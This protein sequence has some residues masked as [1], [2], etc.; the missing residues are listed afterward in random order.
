MIHFDANHLR[1]TDMGKDT[2]IL[3]QQGHGHGH[4]QNMTK[5]KHNI[6]SNNFAINKS[7]V[8]T[9]NQK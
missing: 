8:S 1:S 9:N 6:S 5:I 2:K 4:E 7:I 3:S